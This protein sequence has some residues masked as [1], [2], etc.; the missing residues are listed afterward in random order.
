MQG[1][2]KVFGILESV[3][4]DSQTLGDRAVQHDVGAGDAV[5]GAEHTELEFVSGECKRRSSV[6]VRRIPVESG[7]DIDA[8]FHLDFLCTLIRRIGVD[9]LEN[10]I[11]FITEED[12]DDC[13]RSFIC[14]E[15]VVVARCRDCQTEQI[16]IIINGLDDGA[17]EEQELGIFIRRCSR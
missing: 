11:Q 17:E 16:L 7:Q 15:T 4:I 1:F 13:R 5:G 2:L 3:G 12:R 14:T 9:G 8:E 10:G 6:A